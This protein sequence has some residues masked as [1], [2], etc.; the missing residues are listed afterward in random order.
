[1][2]IINL[3]I[4]QVIINIVAINMH[5]DYHDAKILAKEDLDDRERIFQASVLSKAK[6]KY[7]EEITK[8][9]E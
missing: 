1:M 5:N 9:A 6:K 4:R 8:E 3:L 7:Q 2:L